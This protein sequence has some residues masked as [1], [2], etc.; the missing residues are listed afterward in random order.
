MT[1]QE[2][3]N[4]IIAKLQEDFKSLQVVGF[5]EKPQEYILLHPV[6]AI[7]VRYSGGSYSNSN[8]IWFISQDK[9]MEFAITIVARNLR[10]NNG[11]YEILDNVKTSLCGYKIDGCSKLI[12]T[13]EMFISEN[14][15]IWQYEISFTL[16]T[17]S[18][19]E[20]EEM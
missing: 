2:I 13:K 18:V 15:G 16:T 3:E 10:S 7:L 14:N 8:E 11:I 19:E 9:K 12:P 4:F 17:P 20:M 1:I 6:G 5:P